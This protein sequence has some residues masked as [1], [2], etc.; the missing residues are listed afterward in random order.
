MKLG[1]IA[2]DPRVASKPNH[3]GV[4][5]EETMSF[6]SFSERVNGMHSDSFELSR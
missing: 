1:Y 5:M 2:L 4:M 3:A 6:G